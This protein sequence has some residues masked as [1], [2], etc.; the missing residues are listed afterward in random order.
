M[1]RKTVIF[2]LS[3]R[4]NVDR[5]V[6]LWCLDLAGDTRRISRGK[7]E[8][9]RREDAKMLTRGAQVTGVA[10]CSLC[11]TWISVSLR[12]YVRIGILKFFG[13]EDWLTLAA[14]VCLI[15]FRTVECSFW[16]TNKGD[17]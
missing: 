14:M 3:L 8:G 15:S 16:V 7:G 12:F 17:F 11:L 13:R 4:V 5:F 2:F 10:V 6:D 1:G 9:I